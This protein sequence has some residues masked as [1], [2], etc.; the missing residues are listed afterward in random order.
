[1]NTV[2]D[3]YGVTYTIYNDTAYREGTDPEVIR[4]L[5]NYIHNRNTRR[6]HL[7]YGDSST[8]E[9]WQEIY[10]VDGYIGRSTGTIKIPL[11]VHNSRSLGG[12]AIL[13]D[14]IVKIQTARG[15]ITLY[16]HPNYH[17]PATSGRE[18]ELYNEYSNR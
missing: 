13:T 12:G 8:G 7:S 2:T 3:S 11:L 17:S 5:D 10:D 1:M 6:L 16:Q 18:G 15:K 9:D 14:C 4:I